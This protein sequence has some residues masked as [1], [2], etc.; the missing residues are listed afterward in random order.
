MQKSLQALLT[1]K[2]H[3]VDEVVEGDHEINLLGIT[4]D[5]QSLRLLALAQ[6][7]ARNLRFIIGYM[8]VAVDLERVADQPTKT[9]APRSSTIARRENQNLLYRRARKKMAIRFMLKTRAIST[10]TAPWF[11]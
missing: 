2:T 4:V 6:P 5:C 1:W 3:L 10:S 7:M 11:P 9:K 8:R